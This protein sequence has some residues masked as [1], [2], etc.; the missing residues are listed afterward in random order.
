MAAI[1]RV[2]R[3]ANPAKRRRA[4]S[5][6]RLSPAQI[7]A[8]FGGGRRKSS[9]TRSS[10]VRRK[11]RRKKSSASRR[12]SNPALVVT[13]GPANP[14]RKK[15]TTT[16][17]RRRRK[18]TTRRR[19]TRA[20]RRSNPISAAANPRRRRA[21]RRA[22]NPRRRS[23]RRISARRG[24]RRNPS[25]FGSTISGGKLM[26]AVA[27]GL[28]GVTATKMIVPA[29]PPQLTGTPLMRSVS[30][31]AVAFGSGWLM[32]KVDRDLGSAVL[33]GG[34]MQ[35]GSVMLNAFVPSIGGQIALAGL[36]DYVPAYFSQ[37]ENP[38]MRGYRALPAPAASAGVSGIR[39][40]SFRPAFG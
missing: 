3:V 19:T 22:M 34:L 4:G 29:L 21:R 40:R 5:R 33:F 27:G 28:V 31:I 32:G 35:A 18:A 6:R 20:R 2:R 8:G 7:A 30:S 17:A 23:V 14:S 15:G 39:G 26:Q 10:S 1:V 38:I 25:L 13:L 36:G 11:A 37:P 16:M 12:S 24:R 9:A